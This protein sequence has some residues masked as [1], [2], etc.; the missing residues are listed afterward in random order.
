MDSTDIFA[1]MRK[2]IRIYW[3]EGPKPSVK[4]D[5]VLIALGKRNTNPTVCPSDSKNSSFTTNFPCCGAADK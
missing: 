5:E 4:L 2:R 3:K 1:D